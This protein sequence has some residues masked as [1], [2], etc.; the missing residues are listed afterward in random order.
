MG[1]DFIMPYSNKLIVSGEIGDFV[2]KKWYFLYSLLLS[3]I[4][5]HFFAYINLQLFHILDK[6]SVSWNHILQVMACL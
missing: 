6:F 3:E 1:E 4:L 2:G 5:L